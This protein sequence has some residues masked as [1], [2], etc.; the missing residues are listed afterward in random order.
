MVAR[1]ATLIVAVGFLMSDAVQAAA[2]RRTPTAS[3]PIV[4]S[5]SGADFNP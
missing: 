5:A 2:D 4:D 1:A 3:S